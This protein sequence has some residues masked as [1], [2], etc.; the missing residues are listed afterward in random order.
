MTKEE[1]NEI[2]RLK[3]DGIGYKKIAKYLNL[4]INSVKSY[5]SKEQ[6]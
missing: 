1:I 6:K 2:N 4:S 5:L 3:K